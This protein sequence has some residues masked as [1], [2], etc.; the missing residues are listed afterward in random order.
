MA[1][2]PAQ[3]IKARELT[4]EAFRPYGDVIAADEALPFKPANFGRA[5]RFNWLSDLVNLRPD[6]ARLNLCVFR[7]QPFNLPEMPVQ[8]L[9]K[10]PHSTQVFLP[11]HEGSYVTIVAR[12]SNEPDLSTLAAFVASKQQGISYRPGIWHYPM[13]ALGKQLDLACL[14]YEDKTPDDCVVAELS[15]GVLVLL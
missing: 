8:M 1:S 5:K 7:C 12:G 13:M 2:A 4:P 11:M 3:I 10:H 9:E 15:A 14:I 6:E